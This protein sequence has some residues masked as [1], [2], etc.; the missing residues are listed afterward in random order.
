FATWHLQRDLAELLRRP[1]GRAPWGEGT[2]LWSYLGQRPP[3]PG[4]HGLAAVQHPRGL[5]ATQRAVVERALGTTLTAAQ[6]PP[7]TGKTE[8]IGALAA[9]SL[10][11]RALALADGSA[12]GDD[13]TVVTSTNNRAVDNA[14]DPL[15]DEIPRDRL[16]VALRVGSQPVVGQITADILGRV[17]TWLDG[18]RA[19]ADAEEAFEAALARLRVAADALAER[20]RPQTEYRQRRAQLAKVTARLAELPPGAVDGAAPGPAELSAALNAA[21]GVQRRLELMQDALVPGDLGALAEA[22]KRLR[23]LEA[24]A[25]PRLRVALQAVD[26]VFELGLPPTV[27]ASQP[28]DERVDAWENAVAEALTALEA[29]QD[30]LVRQKAAHKAAHRRRAL[31]A[32]RDDLAA[33]VADAPPPADQG[34]ING[35][36][37]AVHERALMVRERWAVARADTLRP[38]VARA[39]AVALEARSLRR[40]FEQSPD[41]ETWLRRLFPVWGCTLLSLGNTFPPQAACL[42]RVVIDEA[43]QC[44]PAYAVSGLM[45]AHRALVLGDVNQLEPV[46]Q[47][48]PTD[49]K[50][51]QRQAQLTLTPEQLGPFRIAAL[52]GASAQALA[53]Q[54]V[55]DQRLALTDHFRCQ[56]EIIALSDRLCGYRLHVHTPP[57]SLAQFVPLLSAPVVLAPVRGQQTRV[58]GSWINEAEIRATLTVLNHLGRGGVP[59]DEVAVITPYAAQLD[60]LRLALRELGIPH[61]EQG[62]VATGTVHRFQGGERTVVL[63]STVVTRTQSLRFIDQR[64]NLVNVAISRAKDHL[65]VLGDPEVLAEGRHTKV[66]VEGATLLH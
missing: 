26:G 62:G 50:R 32:E 9:H 51:A 4:W 33:L 21:H 17:L 11:T 43:G 53:D 63:F 37:H 25:L 48:T 66:L 34:E 19:Q 59:P 57:R 15:A 45:R 30:R 36:A 8:L 18:Q 16:P 5:T 24:K 41:V 12:M 6:G 56:P 23:R 65:V 3:E 28:I 52:A 20:T 2:A 54:A 35:L 31:E 64:V 39:L 40:L 58:R 14:I 55:G 42:D 61:G 47:L 22:T 60:A 46:V 49:E 44:H 10:A 27:S 1:P 13:I 29:L 7:G 38:V